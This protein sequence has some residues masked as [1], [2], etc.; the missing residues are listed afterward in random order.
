MTNERKYRPASRTLEVKP[1]MK[2]PDGST[3]RMIDDYKEDQ[4]EYDAYI[5]SLPAPLKVT[6]ELHAKW[7]DEPVDSEG[8]TV[9][10]FEKDVNYREACE[11]Y[12]D[13]IQIGTQKPFGWME[14]PMIAWHQLK[15]DEE[16]RDKIRLIAYPLH[17][18]KEE[19]WDDVL[20][21]V[22][23]RVH[24]MTENYFKNNFEIK[25]KTNQ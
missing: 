13:E 12:Y 22:P 19:D 17:R 21:N 2:K 16:S 5:A 15:G 4:R 25:R 7:K 14:A 20:T 18:E 24:P 9:R 6:D 11:V 23:V 1:E 3:Y 8:Y 10:V